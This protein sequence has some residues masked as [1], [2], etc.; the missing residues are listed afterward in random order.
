MTRLQRATAVAA[1]A[2]ALVVV[3]RAALAHAGAAQAP[4]ARPPIIDVAGQ[5]REDAAVRDARR[6]ADDR[7]DDI[8]CNNAARFLRLAP[9]ATQP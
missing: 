2:A 7:C 3:E 9:A 5:A 6:L 8:F 4:A 1:L